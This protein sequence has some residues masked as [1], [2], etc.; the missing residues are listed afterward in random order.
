MLK[1][2]VITAIVLLMVL[3]PALFYSTYVP[4]CAVTLVLITAAAWEWARLN[5]CGSAQ[6]YF[7]GAFCLMVCLLAWNAGWL[8]QSFPMLWLFFGSAWVLLAAVLLRL[9]VAG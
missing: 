5:G 8:E 7:F 6:S 1:Q 2:R 9:G 3:L 4:F